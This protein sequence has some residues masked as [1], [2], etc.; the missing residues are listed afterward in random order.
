MARLDAT[1][2]HPGTS[3]LQ[4][5][6]F[7]A[8]DDLCLKVDVKFPLDHLAATKTQLCQEAIR[9]AYGPDFLARFAPDR[10]KFADDAALFLERRLA[11][12][13]EFDAMAGAAQTI[14][15]LQQEWITAQDDL[16]AARA[17]LGHL[18][19]T[20]QARAAES[21]AAAGRARQLE[22]QLAAAEQ[23]LVAA[24]QRCREHEG[25]AERA[26]AA[27]QAEVVKAEEARARPATRDDKVLALSPAWQCVVCGSLTSSH[28]NPLS[29]PTTRSS[30]CCSITSTS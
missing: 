21:Q 17:K 16:R 8:L 28:I 11:W 18:D 27:L 25:R 24:E 26:E 20:Y 5:P 7:Q 13:V 4:P 14:A 12:V 29:L 30:R 23:R 3:P 6:P 2:P 19:R 1:C 9:W 22:Q 10:P 15:G